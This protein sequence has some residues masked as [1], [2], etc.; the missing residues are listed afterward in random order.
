MRRAL[1]AVV[2]SVAVFAALASWNSAV[3][4]VFG[5]AALTWFLATL[6][7]WSVGGDVF[8]DDEKRR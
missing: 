6:Y 7:R 5:I 4:L 2:V 1:V 3:A 8:G